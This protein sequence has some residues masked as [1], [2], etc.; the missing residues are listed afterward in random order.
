MA[1]AAVL[2]ATRH[3]PEA[4]RRCLKSL[5]A[6]T[7]RPSEVLVLDNA[8]DPPLALPDVSALPVRLLRAERLLGCLLYTSP[9]PRD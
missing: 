6:Q 9:S 1:R 4:L 8:S 7:H 3:R 5:A 2:V